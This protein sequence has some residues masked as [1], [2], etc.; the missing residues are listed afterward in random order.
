MTEEPLMTIEGILEEARS[1]G[2]ESRGVKL[3]RM[4]YSVGIADT[5]MLR[6]LEYAN[7]PNRRLRTRKAD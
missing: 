3:I 1:L 2:I 4:A 5:N 7:R 6:D